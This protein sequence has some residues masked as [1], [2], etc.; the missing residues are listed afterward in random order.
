MATQAV[1]PFVLKLL[2]ALVELEALSKQEAVSVEKTF[3]GYTKGQ[4]D[5]FLLDEGLISQEQLLQ[6]LSVVY[7]VPSFDVR[8]YFFE[9]Q[10]LHMF[11]KEI[12]LEFE[13]IPLTIEED[14]LIMVVANPADEEL[15]AVVGNHVAFDVEFNVGL[16]Q[17]ITDAIEEYYEISVAQ[18][19]EEV[20]Q[21]DENFDPSDEDIVE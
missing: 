19:Q 17:E 16:R 18:E 6:A 20:D 3:T 15:V 8:G 14:I 9:T 13:M 5:Y 21:E 11:P 10:M 1:S 12:L 7:Q 4:I 2:T